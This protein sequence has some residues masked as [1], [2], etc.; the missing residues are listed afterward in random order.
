MYNPYILIPA[1]GESRRFKEAGHKTPKPFL[2]IQNRKG[3][4][5]SMIEHVLDT[6]P[7][8]RI[9]VGVPEQYRYEIQ[10]GGVGIIPIFRTLGQAD[11][12]WQMVDRLPDK[13][14]PLVVLDC[15]M[16]LQTSDLKIIMSMLG[17]Y[18]VTVAVTETFDPN[19]SRVDAVP[20]PT[21]F[22]EKQ[23]IS[24]WGIVGARGFHSVRELETCL[25]IYVSAVA[26]EPYLSEVMNL[27]P[28]KAYAHVIDDYED[29]GT[30]E[31]IKESGAKII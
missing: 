4:V 15:D 16:I 25:R 20:Y 1:A 8:T 11:T 7:S 30:P 18:A 22:V 23:P 26:K 9:Y 17:S 10:Y 6:V 12:V 5:Q 2:Q 13:D 21:R 14:G 27:Y 28:G 29:W 19:A 3:K 24:S 31:R